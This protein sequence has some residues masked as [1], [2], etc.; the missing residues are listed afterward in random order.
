[1]PSAGAKQRAKQLTP[2]Q[3]QQRAQLL[4]GY[5]AIWLVREGDQAVVQI[6][7]GGK[8]I[9]VI[10]EHLDANFC[11]CIEPLGIEAVIKGEGC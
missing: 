6:E 7:H 4:Y 2:R 1:M 5:G 3:N 9:T 11:H 8:V 10:R